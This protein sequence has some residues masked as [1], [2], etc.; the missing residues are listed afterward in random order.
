MQEVANTSKSGFNFEL[1]IGLSFASAQRGRG[2]IPRE[3][4]KG[5]VFTKGM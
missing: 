3:R 4:G 1:L 2:M 5:R